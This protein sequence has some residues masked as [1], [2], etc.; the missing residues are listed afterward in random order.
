MRHQAIIKELRTILI[1]SIECTLR[2][3]PHLTPANDLSKLRHFEKFLINKL[4][5]YDV[6]AM[7]NHKLK[8]LC[9]N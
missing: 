9:I 8:R 1:K 6:S 3:E 5:D 4:Y 7:S 2:S